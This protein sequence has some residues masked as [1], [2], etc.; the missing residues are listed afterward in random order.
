MNTS[1]FASSACFIQTLDNLPIY[2]MNQQ[3]VMNTYKIY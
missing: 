2:V 3:H 1:T